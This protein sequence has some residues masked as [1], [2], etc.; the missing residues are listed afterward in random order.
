MEWG[1]PHP[2]AFRKYLNYLPPQHVPIVFGPAPTSRVTKLQWLAYTNYYYHLGCPCTTTYNKNGSSNGGGHF[3]DLLSF[4]MHRSRPRRNQTIAAT[5]LK[6]HHHCR[7]KPRIPELMIYSRLHLSLY[8]CRKATTLI[9]RWLRRSNTRPGKLCAEINV[10]FRGR[11]NSLINR[12]MINNTEL[13]RPQ[14]I[15][16][17]APDLE[18]HA[19]CLKCQEC[20]QFLDE[21]CTCFVRDGKTYCKRDYVRWESL[22]RVQLNCPSVE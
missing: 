8:H 9:M 3:Q 15:L 5:Q 19:A 4:F 17:V 1:A 13:C 18:W 2:H 10:N 16:R 20:R 11:H 22:V 12:L 6:T 14:Y 7:A 21:S